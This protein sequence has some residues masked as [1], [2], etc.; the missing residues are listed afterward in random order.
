MTCIIDSSVNLKSVGI[1]DAEAIAIARTLRNLSESNEKGSTSKIA[2][3]I[4][5]FQINYPYIPDPE[6]V[7]SH[8]KGWIGREIWPEDWS[9]AEE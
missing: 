6:N 1:K 9:Q 7:Q 2:N 4:F 3:G 5:I 8:A